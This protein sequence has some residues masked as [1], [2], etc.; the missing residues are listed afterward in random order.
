MVPLCPLPFYPTV[1]Y[2][3]NIPYSI[4]PP[5]LRLEKTH[6]VNYDN[7]ARCSIKSYENVNKRYIIKFNHRNRFYYSIGQS[8]WCQNASK[9]ICQNGEISFL[10][11]TQTWSIASL[12]SMYDAELA[13]DRNQLDAKI[14]PRQACF[15]FLQNSRCSILPPCSFC[16]NF[17]HP[18]RDR[19]CCLVNV[20]VK[21]VMLIPGSIISV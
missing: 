20:P 1:S 7:I 3:P 4:L 11:D 5:W 10:W 14:D 16:H 15:F 18:Y 9:W 17:L 13:D 6:Y 12:I 19:N 21:V 2:C 8:S